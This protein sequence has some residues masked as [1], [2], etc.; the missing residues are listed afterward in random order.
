LP[1]H[2]RNSVGYES[3]QIKWRNYGAIYQNEE[4]K[5]LMLELCRRYL[6]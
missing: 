4:H 3:R 2:A 5:N 1:F 6:F